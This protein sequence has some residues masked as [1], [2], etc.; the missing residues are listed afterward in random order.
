MQFAMAIC[1]RPQVL[2]LDEPSTGLDIE[3]RQGLWCAIQELVA[4]GCAVL[5]TTHYLEEAEAL[6]DWVAV[7]Q[8]GALIAEGSVAQLRA[9]MNT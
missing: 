7:L 2:F 4:D 3:A 8:C 5:L 6:A 1:G 9:V